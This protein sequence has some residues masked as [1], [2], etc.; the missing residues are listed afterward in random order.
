MPEKN[1]ERSSQA[2][3]F[4]WRAFCYLRPYWHITAGAYLT[5]LLIN[6]LNVIIP[7]FIRWII[8]GGIRDQNISLLGWSVL[9]LL[10]LTLLKGGL[11]FLQGWWTEID[12]PL[13]YGDYYFVEAMKRYRNL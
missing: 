1:E 2:F 7:Q 5:L 3:Y 8:D 4:L 13:T 11:T 10:G 9:S 6:G 12:V